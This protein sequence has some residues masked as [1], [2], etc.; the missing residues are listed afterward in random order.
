MMQAKSPCITD[1]DKKQNPSSED[2]LPLNP[3]EDPDD[4][5]RKLVNPD[6]GELA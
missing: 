6:E 4:L 1:K 3:W 5:L 2:L